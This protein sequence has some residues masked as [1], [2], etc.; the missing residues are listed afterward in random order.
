[1]TPAHPT[2]T[3]IISDWQQAQRLVKAWQTAGEE[4]VFTNG[5]FDLLHLGHIQN[6]EAAAALGDRL[7]VALNSDASIR[8]LKG[9][10]RPI[11]DQASRQAVVAALAVVDMVLVFDQDTPLELI[12][13]LLPDVLAKGGDYT[14]ANMVGS[15]I[16]MAHGGQVVALPFVEGYSTT[17]LEQKIQTRRAD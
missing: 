8:R 16:V 4:V 1:M 7:I 17:Q 2:A 12:T 14:P 15:E 6:L 10:H 11:S 9:N 5:C 13:L 3:K